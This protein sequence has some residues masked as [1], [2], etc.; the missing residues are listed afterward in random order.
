MSELSKHVRIQIHT[1]KTHIYQ[2]QNLDENLSS[3]LPQIDESIF[4]KCRALWGKP[5]LSCDQ[6][7]LVKGLKMEDFPGKC[8]LS[9]NVA[10]L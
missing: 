1:Y 3:R 2:I 5:P 8:K 10:L 7:V 9:F 4:N 6:K